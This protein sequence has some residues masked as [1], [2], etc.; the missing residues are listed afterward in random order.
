MK[1]GLH[2]GSRCR[3]IAWLLAAAM[4]YTLFPLGGNTVRSRAEQVEYVVRENSGMQDAV[5][6]GT[7]HEIK[8]EVP[9]RYNTTAKIKEAGFTRLQV[10]YRVAEYTQSSDGTAGAMVFF[11]HGGKWENQW[12]NLVLGQELTTSID[13]TPFLASDSSVS[14]MGIQFANVSG[15]I[16]YEIVSAKFTGSKAAGEGDPGSSGGITAPSEANFA[17]LLQYSLYFYDANMCGP[18]VEDHSLVAAGKKYGNYAGYRGNC[19]VC[20]QTADYNGKKVDVSGGYHDAGDHAKFNLPQAYSAVT[21]ALAYTEF[22]EAFSETGQLSHY[23]T[24]ME[25]FCDYFVRCTV[26]DSSGKAEAY[27][28]QVGD[29]D[30]DHAY[31]GAPENQESRGDQA[32]F[33]S[34]STPCTDIVGE[35][36]AALAIQAYNFPEDERSRE[37]LE[38]AKELFAYAESNPKASS[39]GSKAG[40]FYSGSSW[41]DDMALAATWL[42][43]VTGDAAYQSKAETY[44]QNPG[45][46]NCW[47]DMKAAAAAYSRG[48][49]SIRSSID[50]NVNGKSLSDGYTYILSWG[51]ARYNTALQFEALCYDKN[52]HTNL[53]K[54]WAKGQMNYLL[55]QNSMN[56][57]FVVGY[58]ENASKNPHHRAASGCNSYEELN[59]GSLPDQKVLLGALCGGISGGDAGHDTASVC[60][61]VKYHSDGQHFYHD[62]I[63]CYTCNE[64]TLDYN[65]SL[66]AS[67]AGLYTLYKEDGRQMLDTDYVIDASA[68]CGGNPGGNAKTDAELTPEPGKTPEPAVTSKPTVT[69]KPAGTSKPTVTSEPTETLKPA[70]TSEPEEPS[71][72][73]E[74]AKPAGTS[75]PTVTSEPTETLKPIMT[76]EPEEPSGPT[77]TAKPAGTSKPTVTPEPTETLKPAMTS[78]PE[79]PSGPT[80]TAK[81]AGL[82]ETTK[83]AVIS[84]PGHQTSKQNPRLSKKK[85]KIKRGKRAKIMLKGT[86]KSTKVKVKYSKKRLRLKLVKNAGSY[87]QYQI[88]AKKKGKAT[89][90]FTVNK[91]KLKLKVIVK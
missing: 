69:A 85:L 19:H 2:F 7:S 39:S 37:Y 43:R 20:D 88:I 57:C 63:K 74:T 3:G 10:T 49:D 29:G 9:A 79:E 90:T 71:G 45:F 42:Y 13:L 84:E 52:M 4:F 64:V 89:V 54:E 30:R 76:S 1:K 59:N 33:T 72:P 91:K 77:E 47:D 35:T 6:S 75:K 11:E 82:S 83:P 40:S 87:K 15:D 26:R 16:S 61:P 73:T 68:V 78:E 5:I 81:P 51:S 12:T 65:A 24:V 70:M 50:S 53:Y 21:L 18:E 31:W 17:K 25:H 36:V 44:V 23:K 34:S 56:Q 22:G 66:T 46:V 86:I 48:W 67:A 58:N 80:E 32:Y 55:G 8:F 62:G 14:G 60:A 38:C 28:Y 41:E 27:C